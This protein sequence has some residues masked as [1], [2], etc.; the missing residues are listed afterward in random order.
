MKERARM[1]DSI[2]RLVGRRRTLVWIGG[3]GGLLG[4][5]NRAQPAAAANGDPIRA[6]EETTTSGTTVLRSEPEV[7][8]G[9]LLRVRN[10]DRGGVAIRATGADG[11]ATRD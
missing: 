9:I 5:G 3:L 6:G 11:H 7:F 4:L 10:N 8:N 2:G 1:R